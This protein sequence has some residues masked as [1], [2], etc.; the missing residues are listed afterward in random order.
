M[1]GFPF[2]SRALQTAG[3]A[4]LVLI[5]IGIPP[6]AQSVPRG[7]DAND[8]GMKFHARL[9]KIAQT[10]KTYGRVD[11][12]ARWAPFRC[13]MPRPA[14]VRFSASRDAKTHGQKLYSVF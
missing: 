9:L 3:A 2:F 5:I 13:D 7:R 8:D 11:D 14:G 6:S 12:Q 4:F 10:Y 1:T